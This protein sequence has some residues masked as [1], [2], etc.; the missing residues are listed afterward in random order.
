MARAEELYELL[1]N[2][3]AIL[4]DEG[5][6]RLQSCRASYFGQ[7]S[8][9]KVPYCVVQPETAQQVSVAVGALADEHAARRENKVRQTV[10][11]EETTTF[12]A[13]RSGGH[14]IDLGNSIDGGIVLDMSR[15]NH[16]EIAADE[17]TVVVG[18]GARWGSVY[19]KLL[20]RNL[21]VVGGR[22]MTVGVGGF[23]TG[24]GISAH[25]GRYG[26]VA[27]TVIR[28]QVV[29][30]S[31]EIV[32]A[33]KTE[34]P[35]LWKAL[36]GG[37]NNFGIVTEFTLPVF[38]AT[39][40]WSRLIVAPA[41]ERR[42]IVTALH[43]WMKT[44]GAGSVDASRDVDA[45]SPI[46][47]QTNMDGVPFGIDSCILTHTKP[48][49]DDNGWPETFRKSKFASLWRLWSQNNSGPL[50]KL[51]QN[52][53][54]TL[55]PG[56]RHV[57]ACVSVCNDEDTLHAA[58][59][60]NARAV[61]RIKKKARIPGLMWNFIMQAVPPAR[62]STV[63]GLDARTEQLAI[64]QYSTSWKR[65]EDDDVVESETRRALDEIKA[66]AEER[67]TSHTYSYINYSSKWQSPL[68]GYGEKNLEFMRA[69]SRKYDEHGL[70]QEAC[71]GGFKVFE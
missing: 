44:H 32:T 29:L 16:V 28:F 22:S 56:N 64:I 34:R 54:D 55:P 53:D 33:S 30:A 27:E 31:G 1:P 12:F 37:G 61:A 10:E 15:L 8:S 39:D 2:A 42:N 59:E 4:Q 47:C 9:Q 45:A 68:Q 50:T 19:Q 14:S 48:T 70:F 60:I 36:G 51:C 26:F 69:T 13:V 41:F 67:G 7:Q 24:G 46:T 65:S 3:T 58:Y 17:R 25:S 20:E 11:P 18:A 38:A 21:G 52:L 66:M 62:S 23:I 43:E 71:A 5:S 35:D 40:V 6:E 57:F 63:M 49:K